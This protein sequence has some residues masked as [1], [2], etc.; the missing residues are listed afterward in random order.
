MGGNATIDLGNGS[1][2]LTLANSA[3][4]SWSGTLNILDWT[5]GVDTLRFGTDGT[6][7]TAGQLSEITFGDIAGSTAAIDANGYVYAVVPEPS[8]VALSL[9]GG[10]ALA[11]GAIS[12]RK[13]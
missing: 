10:F 6:G 12:R 11:I 2:A 3:A 5:A 7:L 1:S 13:I 4:A 9:L 8:S